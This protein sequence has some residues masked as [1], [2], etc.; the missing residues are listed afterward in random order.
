MEV[1]E[2]LDMGTRKSAK[3]KLTNGAIKA[4]KVS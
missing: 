1:S 3:T 4:D 2:Q